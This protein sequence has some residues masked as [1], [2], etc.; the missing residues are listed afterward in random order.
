MVAEALHQLG[1]RILRAFTPLA[2]SASL[3]AAGCETLPEPEVLDAP[4]E[5]RA[6]DAG[7]SAAIIKNGEKLSNAIAQD[8][9]FEELV[10]VAA[11]LMGDLQQAQLKR[12]DE[13]VD[14]IAITTSE[15]SFAEVMGPGTLLTHLGGNPED[16]EQIEFL[17][18]EIREHHGLLGASPQDVGYLF[19]LALETEKGNDI[20][21]EAVED[22]VVLVPNVQCE[23]ACLNA[24]IFAISIQLMVFVVLM[25]VAV[26]TFPFGIPIAM[27]AIAQLNW[28]LTLAGAALNRC[29]AACEDIPPND[30]GPA[31]CG[32]DDLCEKDEYCWK[33]VL[34]IGKDEC[35][36]KKKQGNVCANHD[37]C[38]TDCCKLHTWSNPVSKTCRPANACN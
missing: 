28:A 19:D 27:F 38:Q 9:A 4:F 6:S 5:L 21:D 34:G 32:G 22:E 25:A 15:S 37:Q 26:V 35:R 8:E 30:G 18:K 1:S 10:G 20:V 2:L 33:G 3:I 13:E 14:A 31:L 17:V 23:M 7:P 29:L 11:E 36:S 24:Y 16:L 12:T